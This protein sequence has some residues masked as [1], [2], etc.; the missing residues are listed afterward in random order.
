MEV[1]IKDYSEKQELKKSSKTLGGYQFNIGF[2]RGFTD[3]KKEK[4]Y[5]ELSTLLSSGVTLKKSVQITLQQAKEKK[6]TEIIQ[7]IYEN[8]VEGKSLHVAMEITQKF[9]TY[10]LYSVKIGEETNNLNKIFSELQLFFNRKIQMRRQI[11]SISAY[12]IFVV[13]IAVAVL[14]FMLKSVVPMFGKVFKQFGKELPELTKNI[15]YL[16]NNFTLILV[17]FLLIF[18]FFLSFHK[19]YRESNFYRN[20]SSTITLKIPFL[21]SLIRTIYLARFCQTLSLLLGSKL[22]LLESLDLIK[23]IIGYY[24]LESTIDFIKKDIITGKSFGESMETHKIYDRS[25]VSML[26]VAEEVNE[27]DLMLH[28]VSEQYAKEIEFKTKTFGVIMEPLIITIIGALVGIIM[29]A[30]YLPMFDLSKILNSN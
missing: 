22:P 26:K 25:L 27:L 17:I 9:S 8:I 2:Q 23:K 14:T 24:P 29:I 21:G 5:R 13:I 1:N 10:E 6:I 28:K 4:I 3:K 20:F 19:L 15:I 16:S 12:P 7:Q 30:M 11:I 18:V